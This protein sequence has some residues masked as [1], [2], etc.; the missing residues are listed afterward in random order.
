[1][2]LAKMGT[3]WRCALAT[4]TG[5]AGGVWAA[6]GKARQAANTAAAAPRFM[7][8]FPKVAPDI[9]GAQGKFRHRRCA[10]GRPRM[11]DCNTRPKTKSQ[12]FFGSFFQ[13]R[14]A[15]LLV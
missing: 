2:P 8:W 15:C 3:S 9:G 6:A 1:M 4:V 12:K 13:K 10:K 14:T 5:G 7:A 11:R